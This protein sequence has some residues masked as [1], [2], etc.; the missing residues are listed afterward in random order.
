MDW[1]EQ[2]TGFHEGNYQ[3]TR[4]KL[5]VDGGRLRSL[6]NGKNYGLASSN[7]CRSK[8]GASARDPS[9]DCRAD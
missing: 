7:L 3:E 2:L 1:F 5:K 9:A 4:A 8:P 6:V